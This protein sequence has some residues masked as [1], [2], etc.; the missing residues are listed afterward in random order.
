MINFNEFMRAYIETALKIFNDDDEEPPSVNYTERDISPDAMDEIVMS[1][2]TFIVSVEQFVK[3]SQ[4]ALPVWERSRAGFDK[5]E[6]TISEHA[7][8]Y[9]WLSRNGYGKNYLDGDWAGSSYDDDPRLGKAL[10]G[11]AHMFKEVGLY[12]GDDGKLYQGEAL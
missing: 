3:G 1:C 11:I 2:N 7:G 6:R 9:F 12:V 8:S 5:G 10:M 4:W